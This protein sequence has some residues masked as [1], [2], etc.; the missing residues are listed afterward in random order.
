MDMK[1]LIISLMEQNL[2]EKAAKIACLKRDE[3]SNQG[4]AESMELDE[5]QR[6]LDAHKFKQAAKVKAGIPLRKPGESLAA[7]VTRKAKAEAKMK[8]E[9][10]ELDEVSM[11]LAKK[12]QK[13][14]DE[15]G[16]AFRTKAGIHGT[17]TASGKYAMD[18]AKKNW[19][20]A[21]KS[22]AIIS[23]KMSEEVELTE[24]VH[25]DLNDAIIDFQKKLMRM[26]R[27]LDPAIA[28]EVKAIDKSLD[29]L[30][31]GPLF[32]IRPGR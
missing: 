28:K 2:E 22:K 1:Y 15:K 16:D 10:A 21:D 6:S 9:E 7:Y 25:N 13:A 23:K 4:V 18:M 5:N 19:D 17:D 20:K 12:V 32:K 8:N 24:D 14:R 26:T 11:S 27:Q 3:V 29:N 31:T 30:R